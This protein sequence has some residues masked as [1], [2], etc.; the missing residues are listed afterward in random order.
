MPIRRALVS[1]AA[2][3]AGLTAASLAQ[4][5]TAPKAKTEAQF[6]GGFRP[7]ACRWPRGARAKQLSACCQMDLEI[8]AQGR[9]VR[10]D[11]ECTDPSFLEPTLRCLAAQ[12]FVPATRNGQ[13]VAD[14]QHFEWEWRA[15]TPAGDLC[16]KL[17]TS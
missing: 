8:D 15:T 2:A 3:A 7:D 6:A 12:D 5:S 13:R 4:T 1:L 10:G 17:K 11:G 16:S 14:Q 9:M